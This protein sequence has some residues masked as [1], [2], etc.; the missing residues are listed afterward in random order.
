MYIIFYEP[1][2]EFYRN[3]IEREH[4]LKKGTFNKV[5]FNKVFNIDNE[6]D[7][8]KSINYDF[9]FVDKVKRRYFKNFDEE[10]I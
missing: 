1:D 6:N 7:D 10:I 4:K 8:N 9:I 2:T 3:L 5:S